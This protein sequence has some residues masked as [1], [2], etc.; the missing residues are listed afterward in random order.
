MTATVMSL[1][2][3][4]SSDSAPKGASRLFNDMPNIALYSLLSRVSADTHDA[5]SW[6]NIL[7]S[8][9]LRNTSV[10]VLPAVLLAHALAYIHV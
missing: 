4:L 10:C 5:A 1:I 3:A 8:H 6:M 2:H 7:A 9:Q